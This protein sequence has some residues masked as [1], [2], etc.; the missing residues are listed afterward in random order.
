MVIVFA[1]KKLQKTVHQSG[2]SKYLASIIL[3]EGAMMV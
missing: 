3:L 2:E 1:L